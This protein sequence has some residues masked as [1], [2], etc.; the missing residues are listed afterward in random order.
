MEEN[1]FIEEQ[2]E[3]IEETEPMGDNEPFEEDEFVGQDD[4]IEKYES[5]GE[6]PIDQ[7]FKGA[8]ISEVI[9]PP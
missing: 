7:I 8:A 9:D 1:K 3:P 5:L 4:P 2:I 6:E